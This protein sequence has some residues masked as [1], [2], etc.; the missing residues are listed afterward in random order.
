M[1]L[2]EYTYYFGAGCA[3]N[4]RITFYGDGNV[5]HAEIYAKD[6]GQ[7]HKTCTLPQE[8]MFVEACCMEEKIKLLKQHME[9]PTDVHM[10]DIA[11]GERMEVVAQLKSGARELQLT[12]DCDPTGD[13][14]RFE[15]LVRIVFMKKCT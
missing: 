7:W 8:D 5:V 14:P 15:K 9:F 11:Y 4:R 2:C 13:N 1:I 6:C 3:P 12:S 10:S